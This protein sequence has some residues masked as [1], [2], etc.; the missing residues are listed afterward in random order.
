MDRIGYPTMPAHG[1]QA[2]TAVARGG[3]IGF[4]SSRRGRLG[5]E[6]RPRPLASRVAPT[7]ERWCELLARATSKTS[8]LLVPT[9]TGEPITRQVAQQRFTFSGPRRILPRRPALGS[10][11]PR[12][13]NLRFLCGRAFESRTRFVI[14]R[15]KFRDRASPLM[16]FGPGE[17]SRPFRRQ[18]FE[19]RERRV[20]RAALA[21]GQGRPLHATPT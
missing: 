11:V 3:R 10:V 8:D 12:K 6:L 14:Q 21:S 4:G 19:A 1:Q 18:H 15:T 5:G 7:G 16:R 20:W 9:L 2:R 13:T 17:R